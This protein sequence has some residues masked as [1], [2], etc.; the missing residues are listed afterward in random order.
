MVRFQKIMKK[1]GIIIQARTDSSRLK[2]KILKPIDDKNLIEWV[3][4]RVKKSEVKKIILATAKKKDNIYLKNLCN[5]E[6]II[7]FEGSEKNVLDRFYK[8]SLKHNLDAI[9]RVCAD[10]PFVDY[11]EINF[12]IKRFNTSQS[13]DNYFF[14][15]KNYGDNT[16]AD[17]FGA[18]LI[19][20]KTL[21]KIYGLAKKSYDKE[22]VTSYLWKN[23]KKFNFIPC[24]TNIPVRY[25]SIVAD[26][27]TDF[28]YKKI[29]SFVK[30]KK[31]QLN[32]SA[33]I[34]SKKYSDFEIDYSLNKLFKLNR[35]LTGS[36]NRVTLKHIQKIVP[37]KIKKIKSG[38]KVSDWTVPKEWKVKKAHI[39]DDTGKRLIDFKDNN[40]HLASYS[41][42]IKKKIRF[43]ELKKNIFTHKIK[44]A[45]P[46]RTLYY[47]KSW[48][49]CLSQLQLEDVKKKLNKTKT[50][51][52]SIE[53]DSKFFNG[54]MN[55]GEIL[56]KG[57]S[58]KEVLISTYICH[59]SMANDNLSGMILGTLLARFLYMKFDLKWS[60]RIIFVPETIGAIAYTHL[61]KN[62]LKSINFGF[63][64]SCVGGKGG[65]SIK[66]TWDNKHF[67]NTITKETLLENKIN[68]K[69]YKFDIHG[70]D[71]RQFSSS[72]LRVNLLSVHKDKYYDFKEYHTSLDNLNFV[73]GKQINYTFNIYKKIIQKLEKVSIYKV[74]NPYS[75]PMLSKYDLYPKIGGSLLPSKIENK[76][77][78]NILWIL[79]NCDGKKSLDEL[80]K[81]LNINK[82]NFTHLI[83]ILIKK[84][85]IIHV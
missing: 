82:K 13:G 62:K 57:R 65:I 55:Y 84:K 66:K 11:K 8:T 77:L 46:Y 68:F 54:C 23:I 61:N 58:K 28:D 71:E 47:K 48:A 6:K 16:Y 37:I 50:K 32:H 18:E 26:I 63:N 10:N 19:S 29:T 27:N 14:N 80:D 79:F 7:F 42:P 51:K 49:F 31:I 35:S 72:G 39:L 85:L 34:I 15:H 25:H 21:K 9:I 74:R 1:I 5:K 59:P 17:G 56:I 83:N 76:N 2:K 43:E 33:K 45:I 3:I 44:N 38:T 41:Q 30:S 53:I 20:F 40:L 70:S 4:K 69:E 67:I 52:A 81:I 22:H 75:E 12:L 60:Y 24:K 64:I 78:E 36:A 73:N